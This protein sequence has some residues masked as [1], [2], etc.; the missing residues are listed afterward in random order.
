[1]KLS[2][3]LFAIILF[4]CSGPS[5][6][7]IA[8]GKEMERKYWEMVKG[9]NDSLDLS[10][11]AAA[12]ADSVSDYYLPPS[13]Y[14][15]VLAAYLHN[16]GVGKKYTHSRKTAPIVLTGYFDDDSYL[17]SAIRVV[18]SSSGKEGL[19]IR[20]GG[21]RTQIIIGAGGDVY[22]DGTTDYDHLSIVKKGEQVWSDLNEDGSLGRDT[23]PESDIITLKTDGLRMQMD[24]S[25]GE[26]IFYWEDGGVEML[27]VN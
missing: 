17:D 7:E 11:K 24:E 12:R 1:M 27:V 10:K 19:L 4:S 21:R 23:V 18:E 9:K 22:P 15:T 16:I 6:E 3:I 14:D 25:C 8:K 2:V 26:V 13:P 20:Y 5:E